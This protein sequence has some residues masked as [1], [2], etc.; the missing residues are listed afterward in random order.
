MRN[1]IIVAQNLLWFQ[2]RLQTLSSTLSGR[3]RGAG[4]EWEGGLRSP[5][6]EEGV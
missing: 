4:G 5:N 1:K 6:L 3:Y 2:R